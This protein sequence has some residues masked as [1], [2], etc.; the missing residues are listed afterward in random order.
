MKVDPLG[1]LRKLPEKARAYYYRVV[2]SVI[3]VG[4]LLALALG[5]DPIEAA[6]W[7]SALGGLAAALLATANTS[8]GADE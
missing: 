1:P 2:V 6:A 7:P 3:P 8:T 4:V 5:V